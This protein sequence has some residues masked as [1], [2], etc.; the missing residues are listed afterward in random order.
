MKAGKREQAFEI[1]KAGYLKHFEFVE[2]PLRA[3]NPAD[4][5]GRG[6]VRRDPRASSG[7]AR[8]TSEVREK[9]VELRGLSTTPSAS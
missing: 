8:P 2:I 5:P 7:P 9:V 6:D 4:A 1:S 3:A